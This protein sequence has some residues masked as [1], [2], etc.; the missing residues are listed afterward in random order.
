MATR[1]LRQIGRHTTPLGKA[2]A[3]GPHLHEGS[4][5]ESRCATGA[6]EQ[7]LNHSD[8]RG[9]LGRVSVNAKPLRP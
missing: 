2:V 3:W 6:S 5:M 4:Q 8:V 9:R 1:I 7:R